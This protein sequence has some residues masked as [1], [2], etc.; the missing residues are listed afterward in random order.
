M[1]CGPASELSLARAARRHA[2]E[3][4]R[5][6]V[7]AIVRSCRRYRSSAATQLVRCHHGVAIGLLHRFVK[8]QFNSALRFSRLRRSTIASSRCPLPLATECVVGGAFCL[9][10]RRCIL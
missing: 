9:V 6:T 8:V 3:K 2:I 4:C 5:P 1:A 7:P 10:C